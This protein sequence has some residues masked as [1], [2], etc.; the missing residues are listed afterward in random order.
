MTSEILESASGLTDSSISG[1]EERL[2]I[3]GRLPVV[4]LVA[5]AVVATVIASLEVREVKSYLSAGFSSARVA[6]R[7]RTRLLAAAASQA[8]HGRFWLLKSE[9]VSELE[10]RL[11]LQEPRVELPNLDLLYRITLNTSTLSDS[12]TESILW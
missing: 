5:E 7:E 1:A 4:V 3:E 6:E 10:L 12:S 9:F 8:G 11:S 2:I